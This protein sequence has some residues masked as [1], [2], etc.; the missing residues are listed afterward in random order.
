MNLGDG[1]DSRPRGIATVARVHSDGWRDSG[2]EVGV[3]FIKPG[4][5][6]PGVGRKGLDVAAVALCVERVKGER[7]LA[8][9]AGAGHDDQLLERKVEVDGFQVMGANTAET[10][11]CGTLCGYCGRHLGC[12]RRFT[13]AARSI[14]DRGE[15]T[16]RLCPLALYATCRLEFLD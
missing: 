5:E 16:L 12:F 10:D 2:D 11:E 8:R 15:S 3:G 4:E 14:E 1:P 7:A 6:L 9:T 13:V